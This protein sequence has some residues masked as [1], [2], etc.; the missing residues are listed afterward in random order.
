MKL[1]M[2]DI[3]RVKMDL[4]KTGI[5]NPTD[6]E[7]AIGFVRNHRTSLIQDT[8]WMA[9]SDVTMT[10][11]WKEYRQS[12]RDLPANSTPDLDADKNLIGVTWPVKPE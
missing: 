10:K 3:E 1:L 11:E 9:G 4:K 7:I 6:K 5:T 8:D 12:L 2:D